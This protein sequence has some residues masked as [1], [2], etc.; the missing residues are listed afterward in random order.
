MAVYVGINK[1]F[2]EA[3]PVEGAELGNIPGAVV[4]G[5]NNAC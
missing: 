2:F 1:F 3:G 4:G 5:L